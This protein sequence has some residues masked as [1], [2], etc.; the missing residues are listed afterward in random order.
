MYYEREGHR[1]A[2]KKAGAVAAIRGCIDNHYKEDA[3]TK[4][5]PTV[6]YEELILGP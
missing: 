1:H 2:L 4:L 6:V 3:L 5:T